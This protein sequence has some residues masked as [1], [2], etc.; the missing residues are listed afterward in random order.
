MNGKQIENEKQIEIRHCAGRAASIRDFAD[1][2][3]QC[4]DRVKEVFFLRA[5]GVSAGCQKEVLQMDR[6][7]SEKMNAGDGRYFRF[8]RLP[9]NVPVDETAFYTDCYEKWKSSGRCVLPVKA[10][11]D[12][13]LSFELA[14]RACDT[15]CSL[16]GRLSG[17]RNESIEK[18]FAVKLLYWL[19]QIYGDLLRGCDYRESV[20]LVFQDV[21]KKQEYLFC[22]L[23]TLT[24][25]DVLLLE[26]SQDIDDTLERLHL[27]EK[28]VIGPAQR[29]D[30]PEYVPAAA[31]A[32]IQISPGVVN[33]RRPDRDL[34]TNAWRNSHV[35]EPVKQAPSGGMGTGRDPSAARGSIRGLL[36]EETRRKQDDPIK[37]ERVPKEEMGFEQLAQ[38]ASSVVMIAIHDAG[39]QT[40]GTGSGIMIGRDGYILTNNHVTS[41]GRSY[42]VR[43][44]D[45]EMIYKTDELIKYN[46]VLDLAVIRIR[47][48]LTPIPIY[49]G[50]AKLVR[51]QKVVAIGSPLGMFNSVSDGIISGFR[52]IDQVDMIQFTAPTSHGSSG[53]ALLNMYGEVIGI[54]T[55]GVENGQ[56]INLAVGYE[57]IRMFIH[58]FT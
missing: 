21:T 28:I 34:R 26:S 58:G 5:V 23:L 6:K 46:S 12:G 25:C 49:G 51:G 19:D 44:E 50:A 43:I 45:D 38:L 3:G 1:A 33:A 30:L 18:N 42:S 55:A 13:G 52:N 7:L 40:I 57:S 47:R 48:P 53:G 14:A 22:Y 17:N 32:Q 36:A 11:H 20:K 54:S 39:G 4:S 10:A 9:G 15:V 2:M 24:G 8:S 35:Q 31:A 16:Y 27:S 29:C 37:A 56:N 41:G